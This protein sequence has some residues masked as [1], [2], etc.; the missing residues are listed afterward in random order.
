MRKPQLQEVLLVWLCSLTAF[1]GYLSYLELRSNETTQVTTQKIQTIQNSLTTLSSVQTQT[2]QAM[3]VGFNGND[4]NTYIDTTGQVMLNG[5]LYINDTASLNISDILPND[6][7]ASCNCSDLNFYEFNVSNINSVTRVFASEDFSMYCQ[8][9]MDN[10]KN[11][12]VCVDIPNPCRQVLI[13]EITYD[14]SNSNI[15]NYV[16]TIVHINRSVDSV[17]I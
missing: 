17:C 7:I 9:T 16:T 15:T 5:F 14:I 13:L 3:T 10:S 6:T 4:L 8:F 12:S 11:H 1:V 2:L